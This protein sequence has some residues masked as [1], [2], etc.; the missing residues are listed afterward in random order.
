M[1]FVALTLD[2]F[3][4]LFLSVGP[5]FFNLLI[6]RL[7]LF[8]LGGMYR[9]RK[10]LLSIASSRPNLQKRSLKTACDGLTWQWVVAWLCRVAPPS[11]R[12]VCCWL[13]HLTPVCLVLFPCFRVD[14]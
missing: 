5:T 3:C 10:A 1:L 2:S 14:S 13:A 4:W 9:T 8:S 6:F 12:S 11:N 7:D